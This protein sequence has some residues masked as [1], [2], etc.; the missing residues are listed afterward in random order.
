M[1]K[2]ILV[3]LLVLALVSTSEGQRRIGGVQRGGPSGAGDPLR[4]PT[5]G[6]SGSP[7]AGGCNPASNEVGDRTDYSGANLEGMDGDM[8]YAFRVQAD[9]TG[10]LG[11]AYIYHG[12]TTASAVKV[13]VY[14]SSS[15]TPQSA[16]A[17]VRCSGAIAGGTSTGWKTVDESASGSVT[18]GNYY[19]ITYTVASGNA[20]SYA[21]NA[22]GTL[23]YKSCDSTCYA[24]IPT[25]M[26]T[27]GTGW[28][29]AAGYTPGSAY[30]T[31]E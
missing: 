1:K 2:I 4:T 18:S 29:S 22:S 11:D 20:W 24:D 10:T 19:W 16:D 7:A 31:I 5:G 12:N 25:N 17:V 28:S 23:Y 30:F 13:C 14:T 15:T 26:A 27:M 3:L 21:H 6:G 8:M 9:C